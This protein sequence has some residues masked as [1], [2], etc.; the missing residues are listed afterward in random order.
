MGFLATISTTHKRTHSH[1]FTPPHCSYEP[2]ESPVEAEA[3]ISTVLLLDCPEDWG[4]GLQV[5]VDVLR[6]NGTPG[7]QHEAEEQVVELFIANPDYHYGAQH[8]LPRLTLGAFR[9]CL[10]TLF[11][12]STGRRLRYTQTGKP[13]PQMYQQARAKLQACAGGK[14][15]ATIYM[16]GDNPESDILGANTAGAPWESILV[17][18][19]V[20]KGQPDAADGSRGERAGEHKRPRVVCAHVL[21]AVTWLRDRSRQA[22]TIE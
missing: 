5:L 13:F 4:E 12:N 1:T 2:V 8:S 17:C 7:A 10:D 9:D 21:D 16:I 20:F 19:G 6:S 22:S 18:T 11:S 14:E 15:L 3:P